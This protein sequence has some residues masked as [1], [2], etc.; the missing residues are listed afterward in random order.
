V[1]SITNNLNNSRS[2]KFTYDQLNR[3]TSAGTTAT[4]GA[5]C[6]GYQ[7]SYDAWGNLL[8]QA[9]DAKLFWLHPDDHGRCYRGYR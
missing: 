8:S 1:W 2:Q 3:I 5:S 6:W 7:Y 9:L 4:T